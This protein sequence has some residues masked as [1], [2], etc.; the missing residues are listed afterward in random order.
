VYVSVLNNK[1]AEMK[2][3]AGNRDVMS[4]GTASG[5]TAATAIAALQEAGGKLSRNMIDDSYD[6]YADVVTLCI[7]LIRQFYDLPRQFRLLG[8]DGYRFVSYD[9]AGLRPVAMDD[10]RYRVPEFDLE[11]GAQQDSPYK[12]MEYNQLALQLYQLGFFREDM[13]DQALRCLQ[14]MEFKNKDKML[15]M[16]DASRT[17]AAENETLRARLTQMA[18]ILD[19]AVGSHLTEALLLENE[20]GKS[21]VQNV[22]PVRKSQPAREK[23]REQVREAVRPR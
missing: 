21:A 8:D 20:T 23:A 22:S 16:I 13:A 2:E 14:M 4:G 11:I 19:K 5:V 10:E 1:I 17:Q 7:E 18:E 3:T 15:S 6:A 9:A 12:S